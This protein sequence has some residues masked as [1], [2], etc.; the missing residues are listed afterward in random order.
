MKHTRQSLKE[1]I[2]LL[3]IRQT[4]EKREFNIQLKA[5]FDSLKPAN[6]LRSTLHDLSNSLDLKN[7]FM[8]TILPLLTGFVS[9]K[10]LNR[11]RKN[12]FFRIIATMIQ[13]G[14]TNFTAKYSHSI[15]RFINELLERFQT[16]H[17]EDDEDEDETE[18]P[19]T[20]RHQ[21]SN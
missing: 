16:H 17:R 3:E 19:E 4:E 15:V 18:N 1:T 6:L 11:S 7:N 12:S 5:T 9:G 14:I 21:Q 8:E 20:V 10:L 13:L 2:R